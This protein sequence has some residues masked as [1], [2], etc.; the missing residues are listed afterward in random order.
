VP[1][2]VK[3]TLW[4]LLLPTVTLPKLRLAGL[5]AS[6]RLT[7]VPER[8]T[9]A[10]ELVALPATEILPVTLPVIVGSKLAVKV[11]LLPALRIKGREIPAI[12]KPAPTVLI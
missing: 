10:G 2:L 6:S 12:L 9:V 5:A 3:V 7:P 4:E 8:E 1:E 11:V